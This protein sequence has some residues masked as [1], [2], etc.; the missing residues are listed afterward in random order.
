MERQVSANEFFPKLLLVSTHITG[1][2]KRF[3]IGIKNKKIHH[4]G[5]FIIF[6]KINAL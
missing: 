2:I 1:N 5:L 3:T 4:H 6:N